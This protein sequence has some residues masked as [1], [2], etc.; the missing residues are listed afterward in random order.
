[1]SAPLI[2]ARGLTA[3]DWRY[4]RHFTQ[5]E[6]SAACQDGAWANI[7]AGSFY[8]LDEFAGYLVAGQRL[9]ESVAFMPTRT[10]AGNPTAT[11][12]TPDT[13]AHNPRSLH[14][15]GRAFD[16]MFPRNALA[17][18]WLTA[19][20][21]PKFGGVGAYPFWRPDP[22]LHLDTRITFDEEQGTGFR[23]LWVCDREGKYNYLNDE[24]GILR[25][26][27]MLREA[28]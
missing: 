12:N 24:A 19:M 13:K 18:A 17:T 3:D 15:Q 14:Y 21:F 28:A 26:V 9:V 20:R 11:W 2:A 1:M 25:F 23:V 5:P 27:E 8:L 16:L 22:G 7:D 6:V 10:K 4:L